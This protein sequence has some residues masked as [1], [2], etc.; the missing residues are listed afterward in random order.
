MSCETDDNTV[1]LA[2]DLYK[3][4]N[5]RLYSIANSV[6]VTSRIAEEFE[7]TALRD[8]NM[9]YVMKCWKQQHSCNQ[10]RRLDED[11]SATIVT[12][13]QNIRRMCRVLTS[14]KEH[15]V[16]FSPVCWDHLLVQVRLL[17]DGDGW[18]LQR[19]YTDREC[20][21]TNRRLNSMYQKKKLATILSK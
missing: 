7:P 15:K 3:T 2:K 16:F 4:K 14:Q 12:R 8:R 19:G 18:P 21:L 17:S 10:H 20:R 1:V 9:N 5:C 11:S 13:L 6:A